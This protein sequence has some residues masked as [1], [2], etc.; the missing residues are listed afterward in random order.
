MH[1]D[2]LAA[3]LWIADFL[4]T[5]ALLVLLLRLRLARQWPSL[6]VLLSTDLAVWAGLAV[7]HRHYRWYFYTYWIWTAIG[8][9]LRLWVLSDCLRSI[10]GA[11]FIPR[12]AR[13]ALLTIAVTL[14]LAAGLVT[15]YT[16]GGHSFAFHAGGGHIGWVLSLPHDTPAGRVL[17]QTVLLYNRAVAFATFGLVV[18]VFGAVMLLGLGWERSGARIASGLGLEMASLAL[19]SAVFTESVWWL[20]AASDYLNNVLHIAV[21]AVWFFAVLGG[22]SQSF[23]VKS[24]GQSSPP[25]Y[26]PKRRVAHL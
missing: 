24:S 18:A 25:I 16:D 22:R 3:V 12:N 21:L 7:I 9:A 13:A 23:T 15:L 1:I 14:A 17:L 4:G 10:P 2:P 8:S 11:S 6:V 19:R 26:N 20:R 5:A